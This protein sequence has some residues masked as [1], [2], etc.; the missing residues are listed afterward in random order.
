MYLEPIVSIH[1]GEVSTGSTYWTPAIAHGLIR[2]NV[3]LVS[4]IE[5][6]SI[7]VRLRLWLSI[8]LVVS[9]RLAA[10]D[11]RDLTRA[12]QPQDGRAR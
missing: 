12:S 10:E 6:G 1:V 9:A 8:G 4:A 2:L 7:T 5:F 11:T 3:V